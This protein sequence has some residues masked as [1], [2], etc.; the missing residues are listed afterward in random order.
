MPTKRKL[1]LLLSPFCLFFIFVFMSAFMKSI[2]TS[3][4]Y[5]PLLGLKHF[6]LAYYGSVLQD[7]LF[8]KTSLRTFGFALFSSL[9]ACLF[10]LLAAL[11]L[12][13]AQGPLGRL[14]HKIVQLPVMLPHIFIVLALLQ[15]LSQTGL[16]SA[17]LKHFGWLSDPA[18]FPLLVNDPY[19]IGI[20]LA[21]LWKEIP[22][23]VVSLLLVLKVLD[24]RYLSVGQNLGASK[25]QLFWHV[26]LPMVQ[27]ALFNAFIIIF[28]FTFGAYEVPY[29]LG[30]PKQMLLPIYIYDL[31]IQNDLTQMP[32]IMC[33]NILLSLFSVLFAGLV[34][35]ISRWLPGG[36]LGGLR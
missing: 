23:V 14:S 25:F 19:Q 1:I 29:L 34:L 11:S 2:V 7:T 3:F 15:L 6:S 4:G 12:R 24:Q 18:A 17:L 33:L 30:N 21:Y 31:Y 28:S 26:S 36:H 22:F 27:P 9:L 35:K 20:I 5:Y 32:L 8:L 16:V 13:K 10:G